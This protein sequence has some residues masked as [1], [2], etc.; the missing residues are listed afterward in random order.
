MENKTH[1]QTLNEKIYF[2]QNQKAEELKLLKEQFNVVHESIK[3]INLIKNAFHEMTTSPEIK[4]NLVDNAIGL[5]TGF[6]SK[7]LIFGTGANPIRNILGN[8]LQSA[9]S[10]IVSNHADGIKA[11]GAN[12]ILKL[13]NRK[14]D[15]NSELAAH[16]A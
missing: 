6:L 16:E 5:T 12:L 11:K 7:K 2:L 4:G 9:V 3:P 8:I 14:Q 13:F 15:S 10:N 1:I